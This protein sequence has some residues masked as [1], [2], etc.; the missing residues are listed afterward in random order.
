MLYSRSLLVICFIFLILIFLIFL[1]FYFVFMVLI[2]LIFW[3]CFHGF[4]LPDFHGSV[5]LCRDVLVPA[6]P[7]NDSAAHA[8][9]SPLFWTLPLSVATEHW[10]EFCAHRKPSL[11]T[12]FMH[13]V[14]SVHTPA[15]ASQ[16]IPHAPPLPPGV[17]T[18][19]FKICLMITALLSC[20]R[21]KVA[22]VSS[23]C[24][25]ILRT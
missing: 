17:H 9:S 22:Y 11:L 15:S 6:V 1:I 3:F 12:Y 23:R 5:L 14:T 21:I 2:F 20:V 18:L 7:H 25:F 4:D 8:H 24:V 16:F 10:A 19:F 13:G